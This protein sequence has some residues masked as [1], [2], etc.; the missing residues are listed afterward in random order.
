MV[1]RRRMPQRTTPTERLRLLNP[2][3]GGLLFREAWWELVPVFI[4]DWLV[5]SVQNITS[6]EGMLNELRGWGCRGHS[7]AW[8]S[9]IDTVSSNGI[10]RGKTCFSVSG[11]RLYTGN[12]CKRTKLSAAAALKGSLRL[13]LVNGIVMGA[14]S[15]RLGCLVGLAALLLYLRLVG[16]PLILCGLQPGW[17]PYY[18]AGG[19]LWVAAAWLMYRGCGDAVVAVAIDDGIVDKLVGAARGVRTRS[20]GHVVLVISVAAAVAVAVFT[21]SEEKRATRREDTGVER[22]CTHNSQAESAE[23]SR[24]SGACRHCL[25]K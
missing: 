14:G 25:V 17:R 6:A 7:Y 13:I 12:A 8:G 1:V 19:E 18:D 10:Q 3:H 24:G 9:A 23:R 11:G 2:H 5:S 21:E 20:D 15:R 16:L 22:R 4:R